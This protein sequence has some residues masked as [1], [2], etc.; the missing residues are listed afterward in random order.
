[1]NG[2]EKALFGAVEHLKNVP[3][4]GY[5]L[6]LLLSALIDISIVYF[7]S[8]TTLNQVRQNTDLKEAK[9]TVAW[10]P[11]SMIVSASLVLIIYGIKAKNKEEQEKILKKE[12]QEKNNREIHNRNQDSLIRA[13]K[14]L[15]RDDKSTLYKIVISEG[16]VRATDTK[17]IPYITYNPSLNAL[18]NL[19]HSKIVIKE[20][21]N[22]DQSISNYYINPSVLEKVQEKFRIDV[23]K[24]IY[25]SL[26]NDLN[27]NIIKR[28]KNERNKEMPIYLSKTDSF[29][30]LLESLSFSDF[31]I[32]SLLIHNP[33]DYIG[34]EE[35]VNQDLLEA[36]G[37]HYPN[38]LLDIWTIRLYK[39]SQ[40]YLSKIADTPI[41][42]TLTFY[43]LD[44]D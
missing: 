11:F 30:D 10:L 35:E 34:F 15:E 32:E 43:T 37:F 14:T 17:Q 9:G 33:A 39:E 1:M 41:P 22:P 24:N 42:Y 2:V 44:E 18:Q 6:F 13:I 19:V 5:G 28:I 20:D 26:L 3:M 16:V 23:K 29:S 38:K 27:S 25:Q 36:I 12:E 8:D 7:F 21:L 4:H 31:S 40:E